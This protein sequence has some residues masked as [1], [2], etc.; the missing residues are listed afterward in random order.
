MMLTQDSADQDLD[1]FD[2]AILAALA[3]DARISI[4]DLAPRIGLSSTACAR[5]LKALEERR[6]IQ[7]YHATLDHQRL[8]FSATVLVRISLESQREEDFEAFERA[9]GQCT[10]V[11]RCYLMSGNDDYQLVVLCRDIA[12]FEHIH[13]TQLARLPRVARIQ[14]SFALR[15]VIDRNLPAAL[16]G[17]IS[18]RRPG[19]L[20]RK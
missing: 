5:R 17:P 13:K 18:G 4:A 7:G 19:G 11:V 3:A 15:A 14:S 16:L 8:G 9:V 6:I 1:R 20:R 10:S 12:D 2:R